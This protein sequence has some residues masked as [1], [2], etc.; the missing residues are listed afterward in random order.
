MK[1]YSCIQGQEWLLAGELP[2]HVGSVGFSTAARF[3]TFFS[4]SFYPS[5]NLQPEDN[6]ALPLSLCIIEIFI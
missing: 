4:S 5:E 2:S 1:D 6:E 3:T